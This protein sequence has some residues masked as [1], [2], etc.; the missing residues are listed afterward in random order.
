[1][2]NQSKIVLIHEN[3]GIWWLKLRK[4]NA[5]DPSRLHRLYWTRRL[6]VLA[7]TLA[8]ATPVVMAI[9]EFL[10]DKECKPAVPGNIA[11]YDYQ[12][13]GIYL[14]T[15]WFRPFRL[16]QR[17]AQQEYLQHIKPLE[18]V[19]LRLDKKLEKGENF[20]T[21]NGFW[22]FRRPGMHSPSIWKD[23]IEF[24][25]SGKAENLTKIY[26]DKVLRNEASEKDLTLL[27]Y[28]TLL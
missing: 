26:K 14:K 15:L 24:A 20:L 25:E 10:L 21:W 9:P 19:H 4:P 3:S 5:K 8:K 1:M 17:F 28:V 18:E 12:K 11:V 7:P 13:A 22:N 2:S 6:P 23:E 16:L 27:F